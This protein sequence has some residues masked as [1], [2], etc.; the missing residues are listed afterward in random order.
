MALGFNT[1]AS[2]GS[3]QVTPDKTMKRN[4]KPKVYR[5]A[6]GDGYEQRLAQGINPLDQTYAVTF[7]TRDNEEIDDIVAFLDDKQGVT[8][9]A[10]TIPDSNGVS[11]QTTIRVIC[12]DYSLTYT[13][14]EFYSCDAT[15]RRVY[16]P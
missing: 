2:Y 7:S 12:E 6:F 3:R 9:F 16:E 14:D 5:A 8:S 15:F 11:N 13:N 4:T 1:G 10:F